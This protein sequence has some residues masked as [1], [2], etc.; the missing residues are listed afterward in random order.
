MD[1]AQTTKDI[2]VGTE[3]CHST[4]R[5]YMMR[6]VVEYLGSAIF[7]FAAIVA[8]YYLWESFGSH[9]KEG[10]ASTLAGS[11]GLTALAGG[12]ARTLLKWLANRL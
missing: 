12:L 4:C 7:I 5:L 6:K 2:V 8:T 10:D 11:A 1:P 9:L 3:I